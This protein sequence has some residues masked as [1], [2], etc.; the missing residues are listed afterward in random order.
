MLQ[1]ASLQQ[2]PVSAAVHDMCAGR[3][4]ALLG[5]AIRAA[6]ATGKRGVSDAVAAADGSQAGPGAA[7]EEDALAQV[8]A[9][10]KSAQRSKA[11]AVARQ[12]SEGQADIAATLQ[13]AVPADIGAFPSACL[14]PC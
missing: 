12:P 5:S 14:M 13:R 4:L 2:Q 8:S 7:A 11:I 3:L 9:F 6:P 10:V 1:A